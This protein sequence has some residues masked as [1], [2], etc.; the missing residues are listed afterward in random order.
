[1]K[2]CHCADWKIWGKINKQMR[3]HESRETSECL[4]W[5]LP[6]GYLLTLTWPRVWVLIPA[7]RVWD[8][9]WG[10]MGDQIRDPLINYLGPERM[11][12]Q[13][14]FKPK[15]FSTPFPHWRQQKGNLPV[16]TLALESG[17]KRLRIYNH[18]LTF[19]Q[20]CSQI[21]TP[22]S[23]IWKHLVDN[24]LSCSPELVVLSV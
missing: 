2:V 12:P 23:A 16:L 17:R 3:K 22:L 10:N 6:W 19:T 11:S 20:A 9:V 24:L 5:S 14:Q 8:R 1:M 13:W 7:G 4:S 18:R 21:D 15:V